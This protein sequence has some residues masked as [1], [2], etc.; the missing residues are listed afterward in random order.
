M[1]KTRQEKKRKEKKK[2]RAAIPKPKLLIKL[3]TIVRRDAQDLKAAD[4]NPKKKAARIQS[5]GQ[6]LRSGELRRA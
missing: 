6:E 2:E 5:S 3:N 4:K 1:K